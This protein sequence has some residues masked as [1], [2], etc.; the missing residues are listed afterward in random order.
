MVKMDSNNKK[1]T[2]S[3]GAGIFQIIFSILAVLCTLQARSIYSF[4]FDLA[5]WPL[6]WITWDGGVWDLIKTIICAFMFLP[7]LCSLAIVLTIGL[8]FLILLIVAN[9]LG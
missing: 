5:T 3:V 2:F 4:G 6:R 8:I 1:V 7:F 9:R